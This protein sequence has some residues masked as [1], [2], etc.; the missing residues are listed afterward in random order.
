MTQ[1]SIANTRFN[2]NTVIDRIRSLGYENPSIDSGDVRQRLIWSHI[3]DN[4]ISVKVQQIDFVN[5]LAS[6]QDQYYKYFQC[7]QHSENADRI[8][9]LYESFFLNSERLKRL[10]IVFKIGDLYYISVGNH[11]CRALAKGYK[12]HPDSTFQSHV[13]LVD[14]NDRLTDLDKVSFGSTLANISNR[15]TLDTTEPETSSDITHQINTQ[16]E[17]LN[18]KDPDTIIWAETQK[19]AW[20]NKWCTD[21]K[22]DSSPR[23]ISV[24]VSAAFAAHIGQS[25]PFPDDKIINQS[26][27]QFWPSGRWFPSEAKV[28]QKTYVTHY[29]NF[30]NTVFN[31]WFARPEFT[32]KN[33]RIQAC[34]RC[35]TTMSSTITSEETVREQRNAFIKNLTDWNNNVNVINSGMPTITKVLFA[36]QT[37]KGE[38]EA[39]EWSEETGKFFQKRLDSSL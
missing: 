15:D 31:S 14:F 26:W 5:E 37:S 21:H 19:I 1:L 36:K 22:P 4:N 33:N 13:L 18:K 11:R 23:I 32:S 38:Y 2:Y 7:R 27:Q 12:E 24:A 8:D 39:H 30:R 28:P 25:I 10:P 29:N 16:F 35:G 17:L 9:E 20:A 3:V 34:V 6:H